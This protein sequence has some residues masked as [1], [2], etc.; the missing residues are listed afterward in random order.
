MNV[1]SF[2][3]G[4]SKITVKFVYED[5]P[6]NPKIVAVVDRWSLFRRNLCYKRL[7]WDL[8]IVAVIDRG[9]LFRGGR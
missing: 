8:K 2:L 6:W 5:H 3:L 1:T 4:P 9:S 7:H